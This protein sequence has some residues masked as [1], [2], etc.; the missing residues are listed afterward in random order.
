MSILS[1]PHFRDEAAAF[2]YLESVVW[3]TG[4]V[5]AKCGR[6]G[7]ITKVKAN[8]VK[9]IRVGLW[10]CGGC[11]AQFRVTVGTVF[12]HVRIPLNL[13]LQAA[14]LMCS[15]K[16]GVSARQ[17]SRVLAVQY[18]T[19]WF[20][21]RRIREAMGDGS[22]PVVGG[23]DSAVEPDETYVGG[24][25]ENRAYEAPASRKAVP[26]LV[27]RDGEARSFHVPGV[28]AEDVRPVLSES[29]DLA[30]PPTTDESPICPELGMESG[31]HGTVDHGAKEHVR[32]GAFVHVDTAESP[33]CVVERGGEGVHRGLSEAHLHRFLVGSDL[34]CD[35]RSEPGRDG[36]ERAD[37]APRG[38]FGRLSTYRPADA[39]LVAT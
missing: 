28:T 25:A 22:M 12:E 16:K 39:G 23:P 14:H 27:E 8:P 2:A 19:A 34:R 33:S 29:A 4:P 15:S 7:R 31:H 6:S 1:R 13:C 21:C 30:R 37:R 18:K 36:A 20:L 38:V 35:D 17:I 3:P 11:K 24:G 5:C 32:L 9:R 26:S 10:R